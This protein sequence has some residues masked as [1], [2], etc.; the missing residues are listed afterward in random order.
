MKQSSKIYV[1]AAGPGQPCFHPCQSKGRKK[2]LAGGRAELEN[3]TQAT[4]PVLK[5]VVSR[6]CTRSHK[7]AVKFLQN[8]S[9]AFSNTLDYSSRYIKKKKKNGSKPFLSTLVYNSSGDA[10]SGRP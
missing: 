6:N 7:F 8:R 3:T 5:N 9:R 4:Q 1:F 10:D 2:S